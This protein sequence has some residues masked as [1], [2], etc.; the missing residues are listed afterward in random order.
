MRPPKPIKLNK[1]E[2]RIEDNIQGIVPV[3]KRK[4]AKIEAIIASANKTKNIN[5]RISAYDIDRIRELSAAEGLPYQT[6][7][8]SILHKYV[9][10]RLLDE[11][12]ILQSMKMLNGNTPPIKKSKLKKNSSPD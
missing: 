10:G 3:S 5:I 7:I 4:R 1:E 12:S 11:N 9:A 8:G 2:Q 6:F